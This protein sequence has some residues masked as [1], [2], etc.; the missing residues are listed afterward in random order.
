MTSADRDSAV[1]VVSSAASGGYG[2]LRALDAR[3]F[4]TDFG[5]I[6][7]R[8]PRAVR[9]N[10][11]DSHFVVNDP[12][13]VWILDLDGSTI[14][15]VPL[16]AD[17][18]PGGGAF[19]ADGM[20]YIGSRARRS[21]EQIDLMKREHC[22]RA[23]DLREILFPRGFA[24]LE[25]GSF[26]VA[27]GTDPKRGGG[28]RALFHYGSGAVSDPEVFVEDPRLDP[29]DIALRDDRVYVTGEYPFG[30]EQAVASLRCYD[31][32]TGKLQMVWSEENASAFSY[33]RKPR[34][35]AFDENGTLVL[36]AQNAVVAINLKDGSAQTVARDERLAGQSL[37]VGPDGIR[38]P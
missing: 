17:I 18:D 37:A 20:Y 8:D 19:D 7:I 16:P 12:S 1:I 3:S 33:L 13:G 14:G 29:L 2:R 21:L 34:G 32:R 24:V 4:W 9:R 35:I 25:D 22:G 23:L 10:R 11:H 27:S 5:P 28:R 6:E 15:R 26:I 36:C 31:L 38:T 30:S